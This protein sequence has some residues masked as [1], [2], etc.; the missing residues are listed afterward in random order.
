MLLLP[1]FNTLCATCHLAKWW[2]NSVYKLCGRLNGSPTVRL[3]TMQLHCQRLQPLMSASHR[4]VEVTLLPAT[5][6]HGMCKPTPHE[7][8]TA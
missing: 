5:K 8:G 1:A 3:Q 6:F 7:Q 2:Q 4:T